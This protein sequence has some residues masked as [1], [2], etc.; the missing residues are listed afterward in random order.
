G[1]YTGIKGYLAQ[2][3]CVTE[4]MGPIYDRSKEHLGASDVAVIAVRKCL[5]NAVQALMK[6]NEPP[7]QITD[8]ANRFRKPVSV[9]KMVPLNL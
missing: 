3:S 6:G 4:T 1:A 2:D 7:C 5:L 8:P 9:G